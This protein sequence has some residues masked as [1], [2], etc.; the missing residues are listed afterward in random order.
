MLL[1]IAKDGTHVSQS[2]QASTA[3]FCSSDLTARGQKIRRAIPLPPWLSG[4]VLRW[5]NPNPAVRDLDSVIAVETFEIR[6]PPP[7][8]TPTFFVRNRASRYSFE[9]AL[10]S[11]TVED[12]IRI[13]ARLESLLA[14]VQQATV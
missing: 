2:I 14:G 4:S 1:T 10:A 3:Q 7:R 11:V 8:N 12:C 9:R 13:Q 6:K 5:P